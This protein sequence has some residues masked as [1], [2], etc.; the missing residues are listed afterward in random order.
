M[1]LD[2]CH[3]ETPCWSVVKTVPAPPA[4]DSATHGPACSGWPCRPSQ[5]LRAESSILSKL[6]YIRALYRREGYAFLSSSLSIL[7]FLRILV[8][9]PER[10]RRTRARPPCTHECYQFPSRSSMKCKYTHVVFLNYS[11]SGPPQIDERYEWKSFIPCRP[12]K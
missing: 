3:S 2:V 6:G 4:S 1:L 10:N 9:L 7:I 11:I 8:S 5:R 12:E